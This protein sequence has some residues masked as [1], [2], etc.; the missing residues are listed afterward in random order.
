MRSTHLTLKLHSFL[1]DKALESSWLNAYTTR[2]NQAIAQIC[3]HRD[4]WE[5]SC[6]AVGV[7]PVSTKNTVILP[8]GLLGP[9]AFPL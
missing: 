4:S 8:L 6:C 3:I 2:L 1:F 7:S 9:G 5:V